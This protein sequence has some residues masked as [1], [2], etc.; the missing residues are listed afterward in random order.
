MPTFFQAIGKGAQSTFLSLLR[1]IF[2][3]IP[4]FWAFS[5]V[6]LNC[7]WLAFPLS[8]TISGAA[9]LVMYRAERKME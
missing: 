9:G 2:C 5:L 4:I 3:L 8:E 6:G 7:T 1:Q